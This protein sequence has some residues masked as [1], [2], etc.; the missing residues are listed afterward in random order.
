MSYGAK[1]HNIINEK[2][3]NSHPTDKNRVFFCGNE[4]LKKGDLIECTQNRST[5][6][7]VE[8]MSGYEHVLIQGQPAAK[9]G[10]RL[11]CGGI[12][13]EGWYSIVIGESTLIPPS[14]DE[15]KF[16][17][18]KAVLLSRIEAKNRT[19]QQ[20]AVGKFLAAVATPC[21]IPDSARQALRYTYAAPGYTF[22]EELKE[23]QAM[24]EIIPYLPEISR[25]IAASFEHENSPHIWGYLSLAEQTERWLTG[26]PSDKKDIGEQPYLMSMGRVLNF[27]SARTIYNRL[28]ANA[29]SEEG[30]KLLLQ[31]CASSG[32]ISDVIGKSVPF[33]FINY[34]PSM[35]LNGITPLNEWDFWERTY[36]NSLPVK[37]PTVETLAH[38]SKYNGLMAALGSFSFRILGKGTT[39]KLNSTDY[40]IS[41]EETAIY[42]KDAFDFTDQKSYYY[43]SK[44]TKDYYLVPAIQSAV[45][46]TDETFRSF[47]QRYNVGHDFYI[48]SH[49]EE[50]R[51]KVV[52]KI[53]A[54]LE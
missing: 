9:V 49:P 25:N 24:D 29:L 19:E 8:I 6:H 40:E 13:T 1:N 18:L 26:E 50:G 20:Q 42:L 35:T 7:Q 44:E 17:A 28:Q 21:G 16:K 37:R 36:F 15:L 14:A 41:L 30:A 3:D 2:P 51:K 22:F 33:D 5:M 46:V 12:I 11:S 10:D 54:T 53:R 32:Q 4:A 43:W 27:L 52:Q 34:A 48:F 47:R 45:S 23:R 38:G 39:T 31:R